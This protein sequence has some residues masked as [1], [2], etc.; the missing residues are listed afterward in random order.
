MADFLAYNR[1][2]M[3]AALAKMKQNMMARGAQAIADLKA[4]VERLSPQSPDKNAEVG[5]LEQFI[6]DT[7]VIRFNP[8]VNGEAHADGVQPY[9]KWV[10]NQIADNIAVYGIDILA[11]FDTTTRGVIADTQLVLT[12]Q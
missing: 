8:N 9:A 11:A 12:Q 7:A 2:E 4:E 3:D 6:Y 5:N 1:K 10:G